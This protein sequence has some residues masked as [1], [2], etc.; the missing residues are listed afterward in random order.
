MLNLKLKTDDI[1]FSRDKNKLVFQVLFARTYLKLMKKDTKSDPFKMSGQLGLLWSEV[2]EHRPPSDRSAGPTEDELEVLKPSE[3][4][5]EHVH[6]GPV[7][8]RPRLHAD[9]YVQVFAPEGPVA[10]VLLVD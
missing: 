9:A 4:R 7:P 8:P 10:V 6:S 1:F 2:A 3:G 5:G